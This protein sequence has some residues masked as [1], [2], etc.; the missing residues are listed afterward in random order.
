MN[1]RIIHTIWNTAVWVGLWAAFVPAWL[2]DS[3]D[4]KMAEW[5]WCPE[6]IQKTDMVQAILFS[7]IYVLFF[8]LISIP[9]SLYSIFSIETRWGFNKMTK[10][11][12]VTDLIKSVIMKLVIISI[13]ISLFIWLVSVCGDY[14]LIFL[15]ATTVGIVALTI[16]LVPT[17]LI[18]CFYKL[19]DLEEGELKTRIVQ[20]SEK[21]KIEVSAI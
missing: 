7:Y 9:W 3:I 18:P 12:F 20:E 5:D 15:G 14:L 13:L 6:T 11:L 8:S 4:H 16:I 17:V 2:W 1:F 10:C 19:S 21:T